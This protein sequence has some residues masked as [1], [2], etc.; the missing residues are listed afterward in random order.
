LACLT[1][2]TGTWDAVSRI[3]ESPRERSGTKSKPART[4][5]STPANLFDS[6][7]VFPANWAEYAIWLCAQVRAGM[8]QIGLVYH[9]ES[10]VILR[11]T[12]LETV[13]TP[14][15]DG[16]LNK[17]LPFYQSGRFKKGSG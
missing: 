3:Q 4:P 15:H 17:R 5:F 9:T 14:F 10:A 6:V 7:V 2:V 13:L 16:L 1:A 12:V 11:M 8:W